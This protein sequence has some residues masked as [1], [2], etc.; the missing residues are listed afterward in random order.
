MDAPGTP[1]THGR[2]TVQN[3]RAASDTHGAAAAGAGRRIT[4]Q[5][6]RA[7][8]LAAAPQGLPAQRSRLGILGAASSRAGLCSR[9]A[10]QAAA[11]LVEQGE[12][13]V[14]HRAAEGEEAQI[15]RQPGAGLGT[16]LPAGTPAH[17]STACTMLRKQQQQGQQRGQQRTSSSSS[18]GSGAA[19]AAAAGAAPPAAGAAATAK[20]EGSARYALTW[21]RERGWTKWAWSEW[22]AGIGGLLGS[23]CGSR[24]GHARSKRHPSQGK[25]PTA[26]KLAAARTFSAWGKEYSVST[27]MASTFL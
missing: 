9:S 19:A 12:A 1:S 7:S 13:H 22:A 15:S 24:A 26:A 5:L 8:R 27:A 18:S 17:P 2:A 21:A 4:P 14:L 20:A 10:K 16:T 3:I 25:P 6:R 11:R 23:S